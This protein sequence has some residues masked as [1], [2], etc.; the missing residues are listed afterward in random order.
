MTTYIIGADLRN[1]KGRNIK[2]LPC[3]WRGEA[4]DPK[5]AMA[6]AHESIA[7]HCR[8]NQDIDRISIAIKGIEDGSLVTTTEFAEDFTIGPGASSIDGSC[9]ASDGVDPAADLSDE[10]KAKAMRIASSRAAQALADQI[11]GEQSGR[12]SSAGETANEDDV[13][14]TR[15]TDALPDPVRD[16]F[17]GELPSERDPAKGGPVSADADTFPSVGDP[18]YDGDGGLGKS[19]E[20]IPQAHG[21]SGR[22]PSQAPMERGANRASPGPGCDKLSK[23]AK[24]SSTTGS[25]SEVSAKPTAPL[26]DAHLFSKRKSAVSFRLHLE[27]RT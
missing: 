1:A 26:K 3:V 5:D 6:Q 16:F 23:T 14:V 10:Q 9:L 24:R 8:A 27:R 2:S 7:R 19:K 25:A 22:D 11:I 20:G 17:G 4:T 15:V 12:R 18:E 13:T 21:S